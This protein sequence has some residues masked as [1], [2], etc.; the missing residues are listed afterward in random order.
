[1]KIKTSLYI[2]VSLV[3][4][5]SLYVYSRF[6][7]DDAFISWRYGKNL[8][9]FG[10][11]NY[12]PSSIDMTQAYTNPIYAVL[13]IVPNYLGWDVVLFFKLI[14]TLLLTAFLIWGF[15]KF[16]KSWLMALIFLALP[17]TVIH[18]YS[19]LETFLFVFLMA[20]LMV[21]L[22]ERQNF[23]VVSCAWLL[24]VTRPE[25]WI[26]AVLLPLYFLVDE[27]DNPVGSIFRKPFFYFASYK[28]RI[29]RAVY[30]A[31]AL[32][33]PLLVYFG[34]HQLHFGSALPNTFY[35]K[36]GAQFNLAAFLKFLFFLSPLLVLFFL[37]RVKL[38]L[39][40]L[41]LLGAMAL[42]YSTSALQMDFSGRFSFHIFAPVYI[43]LVYLSSKAD[44]V[45]HIN[46][47]NLLPRGFSISRHLASNV[48][49]L[50]FLGAFTLVSDFFSSYATTYYSR[51]LDSHAKLGKVLN[52]ISETHKIRAFSLGDAGMAAY[53]SKIDALDNVGLGSSA[54]AR[55]GVT[56]ELL[57]KYG[58]DLIALYAT[59]GG[60]NLSVYRQ[61]ELFDW[62]TKRGFK[63]QCDIYWHPDYALRIYAKTAI[64]EITALCASSQRANNR[65]S[66]DMFKASFIHAPWQYWGE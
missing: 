34:Y 18:L 37:G 60:V 49:I 66:S 17:A 44:G 2:L 33:V 53:H 30:C 19:G 64:D 47:S 41:A 51:G 45:I 8:V 63:E 28:L 16:R 54:I 24:F 65:P 22:Y 39:L 26:L 6:T 29:L 13:S 52:Q 3:L 48:L 61:Q 20:V 15:I 10:V 40:M 55:G 58:V 1:M 50:I 42:T 11:W 32:G 21:S 57:D 43:F 9:D 14:S 36:S 27:P 56:D 7:V 4:V 25:A 46:A 35:I 62:A 31:L 5:A 12:N 23:R 38:A 59:P